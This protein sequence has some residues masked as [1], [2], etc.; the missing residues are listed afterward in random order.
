MLD[1]L[2]T[3]VPVVELCLPVNVLGSPLSL[4][5][6][7]VSDL[8]VR[9]GLG[10]VFTFAAGASFS[11]ALAELHSL[12]FGRLDAQTAGEALAV[13]TIGLYSM[14]VACLYA[15]RMPAIGRA[16]GAKPIAAALLGSF[17]MYG[18]LLLDRRTDLPLAAQAVSCALVVAGN[19]FA[20]YTL[21]CLGRSFSILPECRSLVTSGPYRLVRHPLYLAEEMAMAGAVIQFFSVLAVVLLAAQIAFQL[22]R[23]H[24]EERVLR[25]AFP[26]YEAY[27]VRTWRLVPGII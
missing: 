10:L 15:V 8:G 14:T 22:A 2:P 11:R 17:L 21:G 1:R 7:D 5:R 3:K 24:Y 6:R 25:A 19:G 27:R 4:F 26:E 9:A 18:L 13:M 12:D 20:I 23:T 16:S